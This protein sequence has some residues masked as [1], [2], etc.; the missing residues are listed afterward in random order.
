MTIHRRITP[1]GCL[2]VAVSLLLWACAGAGTAKDAGWLPEPFSATFELETLGTRVGETRWQFARHGNELEYSS[3]SQ[4]AGFYALIRDETIVERARLRARGRNL[5]ALN[6][7]YRR[8]GGKRERFVEVDFDWQRKR[9][10]NTAKGQTWEMAVPTG[11]LDKFSYLLAVMRDLSDGKTKFSYDIADGGKLKRYALEV[12]ANERIDSRFGLLDT[13]KLR[14]KHRK[15]RQTTLWCA[16]AFRYLPVRVEH[17]E[18]DGS[19]LTLTL[20]EV[21]G[22]VAP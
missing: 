1:H 19:V 8:S 2:Q 11:T 22:F 15:N 5:I 10:R 14:R 16:R 9:V 6:Y 4:P 13:V 17:R 21:E 7:Q 18:K 20:Q 3:T 12:L